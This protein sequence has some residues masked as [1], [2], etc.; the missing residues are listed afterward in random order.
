VLGQRKGSFEEGELEIRI[1]A[2]GGDPAQE[3]SEVDALRRC[4][5]RRASPL[6][7]HLGR[8]DV[9]DPHER[10]A[11]HEERVARCIDPGRVPQLDRRAQ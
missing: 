7:E 3:A 9:V 11:E 6:E 8:A 5:R 4:R 1:I 10:L 2:V